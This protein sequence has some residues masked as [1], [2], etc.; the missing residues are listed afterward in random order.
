MLSVVVS[1]SIDIRVECARNFNRILSK[2]SKTTDTIY[3]SPQ[4]Q[5][6]DFSFDS[7]VAEVFPDMIQRSVPGYQTIL[8][9]LGLLTQRYA[10]ADSKLYDL[11]CSLGA[12]SLMM[13]R[14]NPQSGCTIVAV[15]NSEAML[16][17]CR[18]HIEAYKGNTP[19]E[20]HCASIQ[21]VAIED[22]SVV[23]LNFTLQFIPPEQRQ[24]LLQR[25]Y[26][27]LRPGGLLL[28]SEKIRS[29]DNS[30]NELL[31]DLHHEFKRANGYSEL[32]ISQKRTALENVMKTDTIAC[33][34]S[35]LATAGFEH[36]ELWYQSY[37]FCS[38]VAVKAQLEGEGQ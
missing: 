6:S 2:M 20:L 33:H 12:A 15:D 14:N 26:Q 17:R 28:L 32:E 31:V 27:G 11:G 22:A 38:L 3:A 13:R 23:V 30:M 4:G 19:I 18:H 16:E 9:T 5:V 24:A 29:E 25:I 21:D 34:R 7:Q 36:A 10:Q 8:H 1:G 35:R 37:N